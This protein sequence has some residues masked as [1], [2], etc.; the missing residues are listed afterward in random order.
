LF[1]NTFDLEATIERLWEDIQPLYVQLH[2]YVRRKLRG[3]YGADIV[4]HD[5]TIPAHLLG[6]R[7]LFVEAF[8]ILGQLVLF[9][10]CNSLGLQAL[11]TLE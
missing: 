11:R 4:G 10:K 9:G 3:K 5:G 8:Y 6:R 7:M 1:F 2:A